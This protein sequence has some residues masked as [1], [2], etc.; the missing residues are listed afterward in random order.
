MAIL[1]TLLAWVLSVD[2]LWIKDVLNKHGY[3]LN[4]PEY[5]VWSESSKNLLID[6]LFITLISSASRK[7]QII[8][9]L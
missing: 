5:G 9:Q 3:R 8:K 1:Q 6:D 4:W 2:Q 7:T